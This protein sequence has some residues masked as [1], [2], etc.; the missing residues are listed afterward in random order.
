M[1]NFE[2]IN[3]TSSSLT[4]EGMEIATNGSHEARVWAALPLKGQS[5]PMTV[6]E[7]QVRAFAD[8]YV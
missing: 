2:I 1:I 6:P 3:T 7:I 4:P 8:G 5:E